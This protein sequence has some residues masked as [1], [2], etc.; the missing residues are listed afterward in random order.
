MQISQPPE[1]LDRF[2]RA[3]DSFAPEPDSKILLAISGGPDSLALLLLAAEARPGAIIAATVDHGLRPEAAEEADFVAQICARIAVPHLTLRPETAI[4]GNLQSQA[5]AARYRLLEQAADGQGCALIATAHHGDDQLETVLMRLARG[6][7][8]DGMA[9]IRSRNGRIIR[10]MLAFSKAECEDICAR[11]R[12]DPVRDPSNTN[13]EFDRVAI[14]QWLAQAPHP[15]TIARTN[16]TASALHDAS[17]ALAWM[18]QNLVQE[19]IVEDGDA[20]S[21]DASGLPRELRRRLLLACIT[22]LDPALQP[23]G[24]AIDHLLA[25]LDAGRT[26]MIGNLLCSGGDRW[27]VAPAPPRS[28]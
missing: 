22:R 4:T 15:F 8:I 13:V 19:R 25:E 27:T 26:A 10:P 18:V 6:S 14:R 17:D 7:G 21:C 24:E 23:R 3:L 2:R 28:A 20:L 11:A 5:R 9:A 12:L 1:Y 16:R